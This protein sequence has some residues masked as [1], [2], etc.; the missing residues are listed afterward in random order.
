MRDH[1]SPTISGTKFVSWR[2]TGFAV[3]AGAIRTAPPLAGQVSMSIP[4]TRLRRC[5][6]GIA[7]RVIPASAIG[8]SEPGEP[9]CSSARFWSQSEAIQGSQSIRFPS[10]VGKL[11]WFRDRGDLT[12]LPCSSSHR[13]AD[14]RSSLSSS[15]PPESGPHFASSFRPET[16][17]STSLR[18]C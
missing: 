13:I 4:N 1:H 5:A 17:L 16:T 11:C 8:K 10:L 9:G 3:T 15:T 18:K 14:P 12:F 2:T 6:R 7:T